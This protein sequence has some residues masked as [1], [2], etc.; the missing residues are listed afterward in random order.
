[1]NTLKIVFANVYQGLLYEGKVGEKDV[2]S[3]Y[4]PEAYAKQYA[5]FDPDIVCL[6]EVPMDDKAG[7]SSFIAD[8]AAQLGA[9]DI[10][11]DVHD[12]SWLV[13]GKYYGN[14]IISKYALSNYQTLS[15]PHPHLEVDRPDGSHWV[16]HDKTV[17]SAE[18]QV[19]GTTLRI[20]NLHYFAYFLFEH[21][22]NEEQFKPSRTAFIEQLKLADGIP[23]ILAGDFNNGDDHL[24]IAYPELFEGKALT[25]S[26]VFD[27]GQFDERYIG[28]K[29][30]LDHILY[31]AGRFK[32]V[33]SAIIKDP[34]DHRGLYVEFSI[35]E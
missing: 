14:A 12:K 9:V 31:S 1:M 21:N 10:R 30:Q 15:L 13:E 27:E 16:L 20:F 33:D 18:V 34:S 26:V 23:T 22:M 24:E 32:V 5:E 25:D 17:Q 11:T 4:W 29:Y 8:F 19:G 7:R 6:T 35:E 28:G 2:F 3:K